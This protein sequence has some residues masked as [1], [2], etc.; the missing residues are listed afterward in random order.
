MKQFLL[1][2]LSLFAVTGLQAAD[3]HEYLSQDFTK[4][5]GD[6]TVDN[7]TM[8]DA[9]TY[10]WNRS[11]N[12]GMVAS[13]YANSQ[14]Y[15]SEAW[16]YSPEVDLSKLTNLKVAISHAVNKVGTGYTVTQHCQA[17]VIVGDEATALTFNNLPA[18]T[19]WTFYND[20][21]DL[22][23]YCGKSKVKFG[24]RYTSTESSAPSWEIKTLSL[25]TTDDVEG[26]GDDDDVVKA[27][28]I[29]AMKSID[30]SESPEVVF[31]FQNLLVTFV[32]G[33]SLF[34]Q[35]NLNDEIN[36]LLCYLGSN[37]TVLKAGDVISGEVTG[38]LKLYNETALE[39]TPA[40]FPAT[41]VSSGNAV[42]AQTVTIADITNNYTDYEAELVTIK[43]VQFENAAWES[44]NNT[45]VD[46][47]DNSVVL[48]D[49]FNTSASK[50][51]DTEKSYNVTA[52]VSSYKGTVQ[53]YPRT[54]EDIELITSLQ[55]PKLS[56]DADEVPV[57]GTSATVQ[58]A[59]TNESDGAMTWKSS[60]EAVATVDAK[61]NVTILRLGNTVISVETAETATMQAAQAS[62]TLYVLSGGDGT[63]ERPFLPT[64]LAYE[65]GKVSG[66][67]YVEGYIVG[68]WNNNTAQFGAEGAL[69]SNISVA[70][71]ADETIGAFTAPVQL[72]SGT[73]LRAQLNLVDNPGNIGLKVVLAGTVATYFNVAGVKNLTSNSLNGVRIDNS[74]DL[75]NAEIFN[76]LGQKVPYTGL[77]RP[78]VYLVNGK[79]VFLK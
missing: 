3:L 6:W 29:H 66:E 35:E 67:Q 47:S 75:K 54:A 45:I 55:A 26:S 1:S 62:Y 19:S 41:V 78:G 36:G 63:K 74:L 11:N 76:I 52:F 61:G 70:N 8:P 56:F 17:Y 14:C 4:S 15:A 71:T 9:L 53:I 18:G 30:A 24:F 40:T 68:Y 72:T 27:N 60:N 48:R 16:L 34:L 12:Y 5:Q 50:T 79:K 28:S 73:D 33:K 46:D 10:I 37:E 77:K 25:L 69:P 38:Q 44:R 59:L 42:E 39:F 32:N 49:N 64:D 51:F 22:S 31:A 23:S 57:T 20:T 65:N 43:N 7:R 21:L 13:A 2:V 58:N